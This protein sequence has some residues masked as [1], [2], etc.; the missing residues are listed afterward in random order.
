MEIASRGL[1]FERRTLEIEELEKISLAD[2][3][4]FA[5][6]KLAH[7]PAL[8]VL[9]HPQTAADTASDD[10][11]EGGERRGSGEKA[12]KQALSVAVDRSWGPEECA[13]F[14]RE[15]RWLKRDNKIDRGAG[16]RLSRL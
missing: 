4:R 14:R 1:Q 12:A 11:G 8:C 5:A 15:A 10:E 6:E 9:V 2:L 3:R 7:A 16:N 13:A